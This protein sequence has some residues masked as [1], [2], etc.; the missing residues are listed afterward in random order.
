MALTWTQMWTKTQRLAKDSNPDVLIQL[1][2]DINTGYHMFNQKLSRYYA[3]KQQFTD[4]IVNQSLYQQPIDA[5]RI[6]GMTVLVT[7]TYEIP[8]K[9][10]RSEY[11]WR[12]IVS[13]KNY[14]SNWPVYYF[15]LG[16][17]QVQIWP[18]PSQNVA[19]GIRYYYQPQDY[20]LSIEDI[21]SD[22]TGVTVSVTNGNTTVTSDSDTPFTSDMGALNF[23]V[24][25]QANLTWYDIISASTTTLTLKSPYVATSGSGKAWKIGQL[26][27]I[28][29]EYQ[30][31]PMHWALYN[32]HEAN[33]NSSRAQ[34]HLTQYENMVTQCMEDYSSSNQSAVIDEPSNEG[35]NIWTVPPPASQT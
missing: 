28:P 3:R 27:I 9:E 19:N 10:I 2:E 26:S 31:S 14:R 33:G 20:D 6:V 29:T 22:S 15:V 34:F 23:Q 4:A 5:I 30:D 12:Q 1:K 13:V 21:T 8:L 32:Y 35:L 11:E 18:T 17:D 16:K 24:T 7:S 25:G